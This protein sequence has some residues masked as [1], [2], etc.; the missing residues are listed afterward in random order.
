MDTNIGGGGGGAAGAG[1]STPVVP[2]SVPEVKFVILVP[3]RDEPCQGRRAQYEEFLTQMPGLL[4]AVH[5]VGRWAILVGEQSRDGKL[6]SRGRILNAL[7]KIAS[8]MF[9]GAMFILHDIDL[10]PDSTRVGMYGDDIPSPYAVT[11][12]NCDGEYAACDVYIGGICAMR[13]STFFAAN[14]FMNAFA[15]WGG[16]DDCLRNSICRVVGCKR[17]V[18][19]PPARGTVLNMETCS[20]FVKPGQVRAKSDER[21]K[22]PKEARQALKERSAKYDND[23]GVNE[24]CFGVASVLD[25]GEMKRY[26]RVY[27]LEVFV[28]L[29]TLWSCVV[30]NS[31]CKPYYCNPAVTTGQWA[32]PMGTQVCRAS[33][34]WTAS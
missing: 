10:L 22:M 17:I 28:T 20:K 24:L 3:Y 32:Y 4:D 9:P 8:A 15:G 31:K 11:L 12:L 14:G 23:D 2:V 7:S 5:G 29:P 25:L 26:M 21:W 19:T 30:S 16:E 34:V 27:T 33:G 1:A 13:P 18:Y 6:F